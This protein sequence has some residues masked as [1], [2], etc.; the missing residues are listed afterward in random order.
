[1]SRS[2]ER[3]TPIFEQVAEVLADRPE[4]GND[5]AQGMA[6]LCDVTLPTLTNG[7]EGPP[8]AR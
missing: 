4:L 2:E 1:M 3:S 5:V 8:D 7:Q 6:V